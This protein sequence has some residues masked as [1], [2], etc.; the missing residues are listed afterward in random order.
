MKELLYCWISKQFS[1][2]VPK[3]RGDGYLRAP[4]GH[5]HIEEL[6]HIA[7]AVGY[8]VCG[9]DGELTFEVAGSL[10]HGS[11]SNRKAFTSRLMPL[12]EAYYGFP[13]REIFAAEFWQKH[14]VHPK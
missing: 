12:L 3:K 2:L 14:P 11:Q 1:V 8:D 9:L 4:Y 5:H 7:Y 10:Y 6:T 13:S